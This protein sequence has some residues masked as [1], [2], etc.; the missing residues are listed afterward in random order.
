[1]VKKMIFFAGDFAVKIDHFLEKA[2]FLPVHEKM[3]SSN[4]RPD[5]K[6]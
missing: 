3:N 6:L 2:D 5:I 1:M 4:Q